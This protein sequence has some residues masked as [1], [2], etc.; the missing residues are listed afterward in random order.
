MT[1]TGIVAQA[2]RR[3]ESLFQADPTLSTDLRKGD[4]VSDLEHAR[5]HIRSAMAKIEDYPY[6]DKAVRAEIIEYLS[7]DLKRLGQTI[8]KY[9]RAN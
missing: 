9:R 6:Q 5:C 8:V 4:V 1:L 3:G 7:K 2:E